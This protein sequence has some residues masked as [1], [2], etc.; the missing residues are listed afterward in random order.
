MP[1][2]LSVG[3]ASN[4][5]LPEKQI[6]SNMKEEVK[7]KATYTTKNIDDGGIEHGLRY[8]GLI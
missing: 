4:P 6:I 5:D 3:R 2:R 1:C 8:F 7:K